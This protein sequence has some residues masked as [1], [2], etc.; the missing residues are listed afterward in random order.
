MIRIWQRMPVVIQAIAVGFVACTILFS[1]TTH[2][3]LVE[4]RQAGL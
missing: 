3:T 4:R 1:R 2:K